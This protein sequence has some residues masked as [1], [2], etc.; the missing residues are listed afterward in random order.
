MPSG[1]EQSKIFLWFLFLRK[2][3]KGLKEK[4]IFL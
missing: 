2:Q 4:K 3:G 1:K